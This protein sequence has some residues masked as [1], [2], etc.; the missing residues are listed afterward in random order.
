MANALTVN[1]SLNKIST[2]DGLN[3]LYININSLLNKL[4][5]IELLLEG[6]RRDGITIH[7]LAL[8][9]VRLDDATSEYYNIADYNSYF[10]NKERNS[11]GVALYC[12]NSINTS[13]LTQ[14]SV[15]NVDLLCVT[16]ASLNIKLCVFYKQPTVPTSTFLSIID[17][18]LDEYRNCIVIGDANIDLLRL[19]NDGNRLLSTTLSNSY[20]VLNKIQL[21]MATRIAHR[22]GNTSCTIIDHVYSDLPQFLYYLNLFDTPLSDHRVILLSIKHKTNNTNFE[23]AST[24][25]ITNKTNFKKFRNLLLNNP[26]VHSNNM[27]S[28]M[29]DNCLELIRSQLTS[30]T[31][32]TPVPLPNAT[33]PWITGELIQVIAN[34]DRY[35]RLRKKSPHNEFICTK[36]KQLKTS[37]EKL[38][39]QLRNNYFANLIRNNLNNTRRL[40]TTFNYIIHNRHKPPAKIDTISNQVGQQ[41]TDDIGKAN[42]LNEHFS[43]IGANLANI[44]LSNNNSRPRSCTLRRSIADSIVITEFSHQDVR[45][46]ITSLSNSNASEDGINSHV[47]KNNQDLFIP[48]LTDIINSSFENGHFPDSLKLAKVIPIFKSG[49]PTLPKNYRPISILSTISKVFEKLLYN[50]LESFFHKH[51]VIH[52]NQFGFQKGSGSISATTQLVTK[53]QNTLDKKNIAGGIFIDLQKAFDTISHTDILDKL[54]RY[55]IR[56]NIHKILG[57]Y[58]YNRSQYV[59]LGNVKSN[60]NNYTFGIPQGSNLGPLIFLIYINDIFDT[61]LKGQIQLFADDAV[62]VYSG[63]NVNGILNDMQADL[64]IL[65]KWL[66]DNLLTI[67]TDK[68]KYIIF[69]STHIQLEPITSMLLSN[70]A[71]IERVFD[72]KYLGLYLQCNLKWN[73]HIDSIIKKASPLVGVLRRLNRCTPAHLLRSIYFAHIHSRIT[74]LC[75]I[76]GSATPAYKLHD[77]Q[78]LQNK[79]VRTIFNIEYYNNKLSTADILN[80]YK[81]LNIEQ[82]IDYNTTFLFY[83]VLTKQTKIEHT[84]TKNSEIH[85]H[86]T[87][88]HSN[89]HMPKSNNNYGMCNVLNQGA[90]RYNVLPLGVKNT[91]AIIPFKRKLKDHVLS[92]STRLNH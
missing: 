23:K 3:L 92:S 57:S 39:T 17:S 18:F 73:L 56:G 40:W 9:E 26:H 20:F 41:I 12:H 13:I 28:A 15:V 59:S 19:S 70:N 74:Y 80:K 67:N 66:Y 34:R 69:H 7:I 43:N 8:A 45:N 11:G 6:Y 42:T 29:V 21:E 50:A 38:R 1:H 22:D 53:I 77:L 68:P 49:D 25:Q 88:A 35:F 14:L 87:R 72:I 82:L 78:V 60:K 47:L 33:K 31:R 83:K 36:Y 27:S 58:L 75:P 4:Q 89:F 24:Q 51:K 85:H 37:C 79:A 63:N 86:F 62:I 5:D 46:A 55:G 65:D 90:R 44:L 2:T 64:N 54:H 91:T 48:T 76:W 16:V 52:S 71:P 81:I 84:T 10:C 61:P 30:C 32:A